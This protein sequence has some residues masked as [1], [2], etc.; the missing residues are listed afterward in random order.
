MF[1]KPTC[2]PQAKKGTANGANGSSAQPL[3]NG[4][5]RIKPS[6]ETSNTSLPF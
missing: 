3:M 4:D 6:F 5:A 2:P 1:Q